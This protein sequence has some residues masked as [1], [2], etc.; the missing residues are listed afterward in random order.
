MRLARERGTK[1][2]AVDIDVAR[3]NRAPIEW[4]QFS[5]VEPTITGAQTIE[6]ISLDILRDYI[7]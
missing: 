4:A 2:A 1:A 5:P 6:N 7:D 3:A